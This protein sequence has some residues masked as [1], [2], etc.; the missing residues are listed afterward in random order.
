[1]LMGVV[2]FV[3][4]IAGLALFGVFIVKWR[5]GGFPFVWQGLP[6]DRGGPFVEA[7]AIYLFGMI[8]PALLASQLE[9]VSKYVFLPLPLVLLVLAIYWPRLRGIAKVEWKYALGLGMGKGFFKEA[10]L[11]VL[12]WIAALPIIALGIGISVILSS[13]GDAPMNHP[14]EDILGD[15]R[16]ALL[17]F[18]LAAVYAPISEELM[19]RGLLLS[20]L[21]ARWS[22]W[23]AALFTSV[24]FAAVHP[25]GWAAI[26]VLA[27]IALCL[28]F[29][30]AWRGNMVAPMVAHAVHNGLLVSFML[31]ATG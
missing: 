8:A 15:S 9:G 28:S 25:Q 14:I 3:L 4:G 19:F 27:S 24:I 13:L 22:F 12:G 17:A 31:L 16:L 1:M 7:F 11:G 26:P 23:I 2:I 20:G 5:A 29:L 10:L 21:R 18:F 6:L 30:R